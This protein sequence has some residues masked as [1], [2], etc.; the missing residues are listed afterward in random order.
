MCEQKISFYVCGR[1]LLKK[2]E[3]R[4]VQELS[5]VSAPSSLLDPKRA[6]LC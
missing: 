2:K 5:M 3:K 4:C 6:Q 1:V